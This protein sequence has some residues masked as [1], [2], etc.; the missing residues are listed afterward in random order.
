MIG[1][2]IKAK[3]NLCPE[4]LPVDDVFVISRKPQHEK[5]HSYR[6]KVNNIVGKVKWEYI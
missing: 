1:G 5:F 2:N 3:C 4:I 6:G